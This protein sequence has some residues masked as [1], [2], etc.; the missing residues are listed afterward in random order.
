MPLTGHPASQKWTENSPLVAD[1]IAS[2]AFDMAQ[3]ALHR[4]FGVINF[5][6]LKPLFLR[7]YTSARIETP[8]FPTCKDVTSFLLVCLK[9]FQRI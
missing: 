9:M 3:E 6:P 8:T 1:M 7:I 4:Q 5:E 2:G